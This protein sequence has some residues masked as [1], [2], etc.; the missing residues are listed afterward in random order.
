MNSRRA[1]EAPAGLWSFEMTP[2]RAGP[3]LRA[4]PASTAPSAAWS[5]SGRVFGSTRQCRCLQ[6]GSSR[7]GSCSGYWRSWQQ[8]PI[9]CNPSRVPT[10]HSTEIVANHAFGIA[11][12]PRPID[13]W[14]AGTP[15]RAIGSFVTRDDSFNRRA[16]FTSS[17]PVGLS[18]DR[19]GAI[20]GTPRGRSA[21]CE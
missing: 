13:G 6:H 19:H 15:T 2:D 1:A 9:R 12:G 7:P 8:I 14:G 20:S 16:W 17:P 4:A 3:P 18:G 21:R 5:V 11:H 10:Y